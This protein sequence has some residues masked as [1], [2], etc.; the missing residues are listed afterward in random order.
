MME[1]IGCTKKSALLRKL[2][3]MKAIPYRKWIFLICFLLLLSLQMKKP[4]IS[5][6]FAAEPA[7]RSAPCEVRGTWLNPYAFDT[8]TRLEETLN[9]IQAANLNTIFV[10]APP[11]GEFNGWSDPDAFAELVAQAHAAGI[12]VHIWVAAMYRVAGVRADFRLPEEQAAQADWAEALMTAYPQADGYHL[13]Y[14]RFSDWEDVNVEGK[15]DGVSATVDAVAEVLK[16]LPSQKQLTSTSFGLAPQYADFFEEDIPLWF[17]TWFNANPTNDYVD[18][19][20]GGYDTVP[21]FFKYQQDPVGWTIDSGLSAMIP[22]EYT[23]SD[24]YW[25][26]SAKNLASFVA[27]AGIPVSHALMGIGWLEEEGHD[28]W[29]YDAPGVVRKIKVGRTQSLGGFVIFEIGSRDVDDWP[30]INTLTIDSADND[31]DAPYED[32]KPSCLLPELYLPVII[33]P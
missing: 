16:T 7:R 5:L 25:N 31:F 3:S 4:V 26:Q 2:M 19:Y 17:R 30:L 29:G 27:N 10:L 18:P 32:W 13:D 33:N 20:G 14:I 24:Y 22:M 21:S 6:S 1:T 12:S 9:K 15:L 8:P 23:L 28:N 11:I